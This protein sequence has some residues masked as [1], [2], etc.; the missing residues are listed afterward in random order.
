M[1]KLLIILAIQFFIA[2]LQR[3]LA[4]GSALLYRSAGLRIVD[5]RT[6]HFWAF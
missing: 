4:L 1:Q 3:M 2:G 6:R 5:Y